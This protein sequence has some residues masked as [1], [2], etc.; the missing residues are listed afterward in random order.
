MEINNAPDY[1]LSTSEMNKIKSDAK[2]RV[3][4]FLGLPAAAGFFF[5][6]LNGKSN[7]KRRQEIAEIDGEL[8]DLNQIIAAKNKK[9]LKLYKELK[10]LKKN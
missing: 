2:G 9:M 1:G 10:T 5:G 4:T 6:V 3:Y 7:R 8:E